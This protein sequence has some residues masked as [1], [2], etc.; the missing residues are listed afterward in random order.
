MVPTERW[1]CTSCLSGW[2]RRGPEA[3]GGG[4]EA[5]QGGEEGISASKGGA[6]SPGAIE[7][8]LFPHQ[9]DP[10]SVLIPPVM[11]PRSQRKQVEPAVC[12]F[13]LPP[14]WTPDPSLGLRSP[15]PSCVCLQPPVQQSC[16]PPNAPFS[17]LLHPHCLVMESH[18]VENQDTHLPLTT[19]A[20]PLSETGS[21]ATD[22]TGE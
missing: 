17:P 13:K 15:S 8:V 16:P 1:V 11:P 21:K 6:G 20:L 14:L 3:Q 22:G 4:G 7:Q 19:G 10:Q 12:A 9:M 5:S 2:D 18:S